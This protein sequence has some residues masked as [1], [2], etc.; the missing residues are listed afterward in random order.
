MCVVSAIGD[1]YRQNFPYRWPNM[2]PDVMPDVYGPPPRANPPF[3]LTITRAEFERLKKEVQ[4]LKE[5]LVEA[6]KFDKATGQPHCEMDE[7]VEFIKKI[8]EFVGVNMDEVF[9]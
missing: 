5:L 6:S 4:E 3:D 1:N 8:A 7:K 9:K 2:V